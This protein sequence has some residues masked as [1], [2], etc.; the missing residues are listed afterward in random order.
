MIECNQTMLVTLNRPRDQ[1]VGHPYETLLPEALWPR[2]RAR[3]REFL[4]SRL[5]R[6]ASRHGSKRAEK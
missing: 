6:D 3:F 5:G 2:F 1:I 4:D